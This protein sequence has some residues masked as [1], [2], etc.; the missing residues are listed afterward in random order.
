MELFRER[1]DAF[2]SYEHYD[3]IMQWELGG[4][5]DSSGIH[6][7]MSDSSVPLFFH[8]IDNNITHPNTLLDNSTCVI[9]RPDPSTSY[10][11]FGRRS[12]VAF[13][14]ILV[15]PKQ[16]LYNAV[17]LKR[18]DIPLII[19][20]I[21]YGKEVLYDNY[22][23]ALFKSANDYLIF[24]AL[25]SGQTIEQVSIKDVRNHATIKNNQQQKIHHCVHVFPDHSVGQFHIHMWT[26]GLDTVNDLSDVNVDILK[27]IDALND[28]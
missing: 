5:I 1:V 20:M 3:D 17:T 27:I 8:W 24:L 15:I 19:S 25:V 2:T 28:E 7:F 23:N 10:A 26:H 22:K 9:I 6:G 11:E 18:G 14:H 21:D 12:R 13:D 4:K 16:R